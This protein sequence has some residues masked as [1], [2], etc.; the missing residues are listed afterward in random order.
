MGMMR[1]TSAARRPRSRVL[2]LAIAA[3]AAVATVLGSP[4]ARAGDPAAAREQLKQG[5][6]LKEAGRCSDAIA[7]F[8]ESQRL[9]PQPKTLLNLADCEA[10]LADLVS[11]QKHAIDARDLARQ[12]VDAPMLSIADE[13]LAA[14]DKRLPRLT[15]VLAHD[16]PASSAVSR[17]GTQL[18]GTSLGVALP[19]NPGKHMVVASAP[20]HADRL[21]VV[22]LAEGARQTLEVGPGETAGAASGA[23]V[24]GAVPAP[25]PS[26]WTTRKTIALTLGIVGVAGVAVGSVFG[27]EAIAKNNDSNSNGHCAADGC[28]PTGKDLRNTALGDA[29]V[30]TIAISAGLAAIAGGVVLWMIGPAQASST[31]GGF[32][33]LPAFAAGRA[34]AL[35]QGAW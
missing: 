33:L 2:L 27:F 19:T 4:A 10:R 31:A 23:P 14:L 8:V 1:T 29:T 22:V 25:A 26:A 13:R 7:H 16:A 15:I 28:D 3:A 21:F 24:A 6:A 30:S 18:G 11:A 34:G 17:D 35:V 12:N 20:G 5:Y 32:R 9:D